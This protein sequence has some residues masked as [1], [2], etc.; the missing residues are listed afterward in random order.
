MGMDTPQWLSV[1]QSTVKAE[2][3]ALGRI[4]RYVDDLQAETAKLDE[5]MSGGALLPGMAMG[6]SLLAEGHYRDRLQLEREAMETRLQL[7]EE[8]FQQQRLRVLRAQR[9]LEVAEDIVAEEARQAKQQGE[10]RSE[11][12]VSDVAGWGRRGS[13]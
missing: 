1:R 9:A 6:A 12:A 5:A 8:A 10:R 13:R 7:A 2:E 3:S 11:Q 4:Q